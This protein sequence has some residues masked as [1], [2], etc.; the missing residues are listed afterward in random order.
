MDEEK[1]N[2]LNEKA[3]HTLLSFPSELPSSFLLLS[4]SHVT[5]IPK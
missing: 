1:E 3:L 5:K 4:A 2:Y